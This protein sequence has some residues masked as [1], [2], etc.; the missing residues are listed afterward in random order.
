MNWNSP[1]D[2]V[3]AKALIQEIGHTIDDIASR[4]GSKLAYRFVND[5]YDGQDVFDSYGT[6]NFQK[7]SSISQAYDIDGIFQE[8]QNGGWLIGGKS[9]G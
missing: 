8:L 5:A 4:H 1:N 6:E 2:D 3:A 9:D 7:L